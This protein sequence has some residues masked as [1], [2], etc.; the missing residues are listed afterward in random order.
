VI[1]EIDLLVVQEDL[2]LEVVILERQMIL[3]EEIE[4]IL[5][6]IPLEGG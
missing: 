2:G 3:E 1:E 6:E 5:K 4:V